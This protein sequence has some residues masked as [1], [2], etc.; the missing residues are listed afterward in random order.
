[1]ERCGRRKRIRLRC[2]VATCGGEGADACAQLNCVFIE[3][4]SCGRPNHSAGVSYASVS[5]L[6][7]SSIPSDFIT[8]SDLL[9]LQ[10]NV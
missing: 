3:R 5:L 8:F 4:A 10:H 1:M 9:E 7:L 2:G 6:D